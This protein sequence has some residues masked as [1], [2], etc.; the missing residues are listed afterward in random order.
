MKESQKQVRLG[1]FGRAGRELI[2]VLTGL[3]EETKPRWWG[4]LQHL[5]WTLHI[6][7]R[8]NVWQKRCIPY[9]DKEFALKR[10]LRMAWE[11]GRKTD[12]ARI[13]YWSRTN[14]VFCRGGGGAFFSC[15]V[16][17]PG[18]VRPTSTI[19]IRLESDRLCLTFGRKY[20]SLSHKH[21][22]IPLSKVSNIK[23]PSL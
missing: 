4:P 5:G 20:P 9:K 8:G 12:K 10:S 13:K 1:S 15:G 14:S 18:G 2:A 21:G 16:F 7:E 23:I 11:R 3:E 6:L 22:S 19:R 17:L